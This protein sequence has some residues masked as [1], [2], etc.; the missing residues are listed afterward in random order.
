MTT[1]TIPKKFTKGEELIII[2]RQDYEK[3]LS[4]PKRKKFDP[5]L[6]EALEDVR[7]GRVIG[8]FSNLKEGL[9]ALKRAR[10]N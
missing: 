1:I 4:L 3:L 6:E 10:P 9:A 8:P 5:G 7:K 2:P